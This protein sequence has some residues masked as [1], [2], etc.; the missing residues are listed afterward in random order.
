[1]GLAQYLSRYQYT[2]SWNNKRRLVVVEGDTM[3]EQ[4]R[5]S[6]LAE[7]MNCQLSTRNLNIIYLS[8]DNPR[9]LAFYPN[10]DPDVENLDQEVVKNIKNDIGQMS[11]EWAALVGYD[12][13]VKMVVREEVE[14][15][16]IFSTIDRMPMRRREILGGAVCP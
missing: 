6:V 11:G 16:T 13:G 8:G 3:V 7:G 4:V 12:G 2:T 1:M 9:D 14:W 5:R 15:D 10:R